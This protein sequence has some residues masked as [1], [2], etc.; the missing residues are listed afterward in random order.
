MNKLKNFSVRKC[1]YF[2]LFVLIELCVV[3][4]FT[5]YNLRRNGFPLNSLML[6]SD[7]QF[8]DY[9]MH[10]GYASVPWGTNIYDFSTNTCFPPLAYLMYGFLA[11]IVGYQAANPKDIT[12]H[13]FVGNNLTIFLVYSI[14]CIILCIYAI[15][16]FQKK[17]G[18]IYQVLFP[19]LLVFSYP[20]AFTTIQRGNSVLLV[21]V[22]MSIALSWRDEKSKVK[23]ELALIFI[24]VCAGLKIYPA[25][26]GIMYIKEKRFAETIRLAL[27]GVVL[28]F[29]PFVFFGGM[30]GLQSFLNT[31]FTLN[32]EVHRSS[33]SGIVEMITKMLFGVSVPTLNFVIQQAFLLL[34]IVS[35]FLCKEKW[36]G[37]LIL[38]SIMTV[39]ISSSW[40][41]TCVYI[42]PAMLMFFREKDDRPIRISRE[43]WVDIVGMLLFVI[44]FSIP[45]KVNYP[46]IYGSIIV[47]DSVYM[48]TAIVRFIKR[49]VHKK[50]MT[51]VKG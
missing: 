44:T 16:L 13:Q 30:E 3:T 14:V 1:S 33:I 8:G 6:E 36:G 15:R 48:V 7:D 35:F 11:R 49:A 23:R 28:F 47:L 12:S 50:S 40:M 46:F 27:Y 2:Q 10:I 26:L 5:L 24:A 41:Y 34:S 39:Y 17:N 31:V 22:L 20:F 51:R 19:C 9:F 25:I 18:I 29:V 42:L 4:L 21:A 37:T 38:C 45:Q 32:G 43:N